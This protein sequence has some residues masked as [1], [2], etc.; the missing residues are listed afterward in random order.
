M[1]V[2]L[3]FSSCRSGGFRHGLP[4]LALKEP[5]RLI[6]KYEPPEP[7]LLTLKGQ[8]KQARFSPE[9]RFILYI[10][11]DRENHKHSQVYEMDLDSREERRVT[12][13]DGDNRDP[14][15]HPKGQQIIYS[16]STD[17]LKENPPFI[18]AALAY[19]S[20]QVSAEAIETHFVEGRTPSSHSDIASTTSPVFSPHD[21]TQRCFNVL[22]MKSGEKCGRGEWDEN[23]D[24][25]GRKVAS[26]SSTLSLAVGGGEG[27]GLEEGRAPLLPYEIY[28]S[29][30][31]GSQIQR[32]TNSPDF[33]AEA[34]YHPT[35]EFLVFST[36][37]TGQLKIFKMA[38][39][40][41]GQ[42]AWS[43]GQYLDSEAYFS[44][45]GKSLVWVRYSENV[46]ESQ[47]YRARS[48]FEEARPLTTRKAQHSSPVWHPDNEHIIF[49][50]NRAPAGGFELYVMKNDGSCMNRLTYSSGDDQ[51]PEISPDGT[52]ILFTSDR[53]GYEQI[54]M[55]DFKVPTTCPE[56]IH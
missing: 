15:Y 10:S 42:T 46:S 36:V 55:L 3:C 27:R 13:Q 5:R 7:E 14:S 9:G 24:S 47:I 17:E 1:F 34:R 32:L 12:F 45:D 25:N 20:H 28:A 39:D 43:R 44:Q 53:S 35:G 48:N 51:S 40:G 19:M 11:K 18:R 29:H 16:S 41:R 22:A 52:K 31:D 50:S 23:F 54:Y 33:D 49:S 30:R 38:S 2:I 37:R 21:F 56:S 8:N 26:L 4:S 6:Q